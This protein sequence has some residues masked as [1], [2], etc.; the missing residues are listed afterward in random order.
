MSLPH[1]TDGGIM[2]PIISITTP[3]FSNQ[4]VES[5]R[6]FYYTFEPGTCLVNGLYF[7]FFFF[8]F[9]FPLTPLYEH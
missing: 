2:H 6:N 7:F 8:F 1:T 5:F 9:F 3:L 4:S